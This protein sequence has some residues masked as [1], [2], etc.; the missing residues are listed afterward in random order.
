M[1][2]F[3]KAVLRGLA[4]V[5]VLPA[6]ASYAI[7]SRVIGADRALEGSTQAL[8]LLPGLFGQYLRRAF[9]ARVL[10]GCD[11]TAAVCFGT[12]FSQG[13]ARI[14]ARAYVGPN[15][16]LGRVHVERDV[17][18]ASGVQITSGRL[19]HGSGDASVPIRDQEG[20]RTLVRIGEG[21]WIGAGCVVMAD[22]GRHSIVGAGSVVTRPIPDRV[23]AAGAPARVIRARDTETPSRDRNPQSSIRNPQ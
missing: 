12:T 21:A 8:A 2:D 15:C 23:V 18:I 19:T 14:D 11:A 17:L 13:G 9:L 16:V 5:A 20:A 7:R 22:V 10:A 6:L 1:R 3:A 4:L